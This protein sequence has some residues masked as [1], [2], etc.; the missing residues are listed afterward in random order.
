MVQNVRDLLEL[1]VL[2]WRNYS[3]HVLA[4]TSSKQDRVAE[5]LPLTGDLCKLRLFLFTEWL[6]K[7]LNE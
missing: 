2:E 7:W 5:P 6:N 3:S 1:Q 4:T